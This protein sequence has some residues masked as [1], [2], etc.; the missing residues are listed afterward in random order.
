M[1]ARDAGQAAAS[2][3]AC[4]ALAAADAAFLHPLAKATQ[5]KHIL[6]SA[7]H[8]ARAFELAAGDDPAAGACHIAQARI[9]ALRSWPRSLGATQPPRAAEG[10]SGN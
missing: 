9:L 10:E 2:D 4:A 6:G 7:A 8:A 1:G 3:A 5:A